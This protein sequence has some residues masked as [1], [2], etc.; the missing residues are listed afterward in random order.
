MS[1]FHPVA[2]SLLNF[3]NTISTI[4]T[5]RLFIY[6][7]CSYQDKHQRLS[8][9]HSSQSLEIPRWTSSQHEGLSGSF[10]L[11]S[12][13]SCTRTTKET[14]R[15][16]KCNQY[17]PFIIKRILGI[18]DIFPCSFGNKRMHLLTRV[19]GI[20]VKIKVL[21]LICVCYNPAIAGKLQEPKRTSHATLETFAREQIT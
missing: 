15:F 7:S 19:C 13:L 4:S 9:H 14:S 6:I 11:P 20:Y 10:Y 1:T 17:L 18:R 2:S 8:W 3:N 12:T 16:W 5:T 21:Q